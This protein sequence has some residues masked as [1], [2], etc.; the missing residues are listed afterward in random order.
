MKMIKQDGRD[1]DPSV[2]TTGLARPR[3]GLWKASRARSARLCRPEKPRRDLII[4][5]KREGDDMDRSVATMGLA[6]PRSGLRRASRAR[7][8]HLF[9]P[10]KPWSD[11]ER[12]TYIPLNVLYRESHG[13]VS[14]MRAR[15]RSSIRCS[16][17][18]W[19]DDCEE[20]R[21]FKMRCCGTRM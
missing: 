6:R 10:E 9:R 15:E 21:W 3:S 13:G 18:W 14:T 19:R 16:D 12:R 1:M 4:R 8:A 11:R 2:A 5:V 20:R 17:A 7:S